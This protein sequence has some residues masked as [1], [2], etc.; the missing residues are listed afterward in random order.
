M[1]PLFFCL[2]VLC[3]CAGVDYVGLPGTKLL[4]D[5][6]TGGKLGVAPAITFNPRTG[7]T[8]P[9][10]PRNLALLAKALSGKMNLDKKQQLYDEPQGKLD[11]SYK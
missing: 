9:I 3:V 6:M 8:F 4:N 1:G 2:F 5:A 7:Y 10:V 11:D